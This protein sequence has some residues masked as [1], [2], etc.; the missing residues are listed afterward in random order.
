MLSLSKLY[1]YPLWGAS[2]INQNELL[3]KLVK[4]RLSRDAL[5]ESS[6]SPP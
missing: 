1:I 4:F 2:T 6:S 3:L 5:L